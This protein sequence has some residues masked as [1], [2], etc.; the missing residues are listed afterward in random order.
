MLTESGNS[1]ILHGAL[2]LADAADLRDSLLGVIVAGDD[3]Y[4][5]GSEVL[6]VSTPCI[7][8]LFAAALEVES[9]GGHF[10]LVQPSQILKDAMTDL[11]LA[12]LL[13]HWSDDE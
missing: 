8:V 3:L 2:T 13:K 12:G 1:F 4:L 7:Q 9:T 6:R 10:R 5:N 11:G